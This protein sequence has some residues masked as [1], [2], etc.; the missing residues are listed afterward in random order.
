MS[1]PS[2]IYSYGFPILAVAPSLPWMRPWQAKSPIKLS[3]PFFRCPTISIRGSVL[4][5]V[6]SYV[7]K[8]AKTSDFQA[9]AIPLDS[10]TTTYT[11]AATT[12][13]TTTAHHLTHT[14]EDASL[15]Y[16]PCCQATRPRRTIPATAITWQRYFQ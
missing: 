14:A 12:T 7:R 11:T 16:W 3:C 10:P 13:L 2:Y 15:A 8:T 1:P 6:C 9:E 4:L 5:F